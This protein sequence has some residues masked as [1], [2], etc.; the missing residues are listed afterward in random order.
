MI[1]VGFGLRFL[2]HDVHVYVRFCNSYVEWVSFCG[3]LCRPR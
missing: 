3:I 2:S 1:D